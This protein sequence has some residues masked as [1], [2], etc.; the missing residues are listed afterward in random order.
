MEKHLRHLNEDVFKAFPILKSKRLCLRDIR[1]QDAQQ[2]FD[3]RAN[4][5]VNTFIARETMTEAEQAISLVEKCKIGFQEKKAIPWAGVLRDNAKIIGTCGF[6]SIDVPNLHAEIGG[7]MATAYWGKGIAQE[8]VEMILNFGIEVFGLQTIE[9]KVAPK[10]R[11]AIAVLEGLGFVKEAHFKD[12]M[13]F[14]GNFWDL[15]VY[16]KHAQ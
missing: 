13:F 14:Q 5:R 2:I 8:A 15:A 9:A 6:N 4:G 3:M 1:N 12:R 11:G 7:E 10:N 16:T